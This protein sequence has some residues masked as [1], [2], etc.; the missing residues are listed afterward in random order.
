MSSHTWCS[1]TTSQLHFGLCPVPG[2]LKL[3]RTDTVCK[4]LLHRGIREKCHLFGAFIMGGGGSALLAV[5]PDFAIESIWDSCGCGVS[6]S[7]CLFFLMTISWSLTS[8]SSL[9]CD[10]ENPSWWQASAL[11]VPRCWL[12]SSVEGEFCPLFLSIRFL[13]LSL[14]LNFHNAWDR[15]PDGVC[16]DSCRLSSLFVFDPLIG[17]FNYSVFEPTWSILGLIMLLFIA[18]FS[19]MIILLF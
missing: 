14:L 16:Y 17:N 5:W 8:D 18:F 10:F 3:L 4:I 15:S 2:S 13:A 12:P 11:R 9:W 7:S 6:V 1:C 19:V